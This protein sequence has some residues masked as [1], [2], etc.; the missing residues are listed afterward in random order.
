MLIVL[1]SIQ[2][3]GAFHEVYTPCKSVTLGGHF[4][5]YD[6]L[7]LTAVSRRFD[8]VNNNSATNQ[9]HSCVPMLLSAMMVSI[10]MH[11]KSSMWFFTPVFYSSNSPRQLFD[12]RPSLHYVAKSCTQTGT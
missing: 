3:P 12:A 11:S 5:T 4:L 1:S 2:P 10:T 8:V 7:H 9:D 6:S